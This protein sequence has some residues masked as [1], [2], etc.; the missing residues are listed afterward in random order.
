[1]ESVGMESNVATEAERSNEVKLKMKFTGKVAKIGLAGAI[2]DLGIGRPAVLHISQILPPS[3]NEPIKR[4]EDVLH[5]GQDIEVWVR[6]AKGE[7]IELTMFKPLDLEWREIKPG[8]T[9]KGKVT[10]LEKFGAFVEIGAERPG[11]V[12]I[13]EMAHGYVKTPAD[14]VKED[15]EVEAQV[16][17]VNR[18]KKQIKLSLKALQPE[19]QP[20]PVVVVETPPVHN[21]EETQAQKEK[22][23][24]RKRTPRKGRRGGE[25]SAE[26]DQVMVEMPQ[27]EADPTYM[28]LALREAM[29]KAKSRRQ[30][31]DRNKPSRK[32]SKE[33]EEILSRT[34]EHKTRTS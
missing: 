1:M 29:E 23:K 32:V 4:V 21:F 9:V 11:L 19:P 7:R 27:A 26:A 30:H 3:D 25:T 6:K 33:Q 22:A 14:V 28:E 31:D 8:M 5:V 13:S 34:L 17:E 12:H 18:R 15:E 10:R 16:L 24:G 2:I 20:Q